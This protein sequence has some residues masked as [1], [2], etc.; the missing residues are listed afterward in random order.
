MS[1]KLKEMTNEER[2]QLF[3]IILKPYNPN[4]NQWYHQEELRLKS[5]IGM[6]NIMRINHIGS[7]SVH[8]L[9]SK[10][11]IDI[12]LEVKDE[13]IISFI[14]KNIESNGYICLRQTDGFNH[15]SLLC[16]KGYGEKGFEEK[17]FHVH[18]RLINDH[19]ELYFRDYLR[20]HPH[21]A[22]KY[23]DLKI[24]LMKKYKHH[25]DHYTDHKTDFIKTYTQM[26]KTLYPNRYKPK[27]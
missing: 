23:G 11:T 12:L 6:D 20:D 4:Y 9:L 3:P 24:E 17:V 25:R 14:A 15:P 26:A 18:I 16:L 13:S 1:S 7:T 2:W 19:K 21:I 22:E 5:L 27:K 8:G 10:P